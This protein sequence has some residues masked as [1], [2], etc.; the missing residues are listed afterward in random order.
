MLYPVCAKC[1][2]TNLSVAPRSAEGSPLMAYCPECHSM[3][4]VNQ[5][6]HAIAEDEPKLLSWTKI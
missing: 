4:Y 5:P 3:Y 6:D 1:R 2:N